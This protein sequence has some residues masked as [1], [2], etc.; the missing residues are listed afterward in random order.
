MENF[1]TLG[2]ECRL[3]QVTIKAVEITLSLDQIDFI[4]RHLQKKKYI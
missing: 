1:G 4:R 3:L 2:T